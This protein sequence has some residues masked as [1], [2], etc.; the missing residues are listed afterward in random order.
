MSPSDRLLL[1]SQLVDELPEGATKR[2]VSAFAAATFVVVR[3]MQ[4]R[5]TEAEARFAVARARDEL[6]AVGSR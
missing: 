5:A 6:L 2:I 4:G 3:H 1:L